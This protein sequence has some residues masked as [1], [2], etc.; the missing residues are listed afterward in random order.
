MFAKLTHR[1]TKDL[2][3]VYANLAAGKVIGQSIA[4]TSKPFYTNCP[5]YVNFGPTM[6]C[7]L[8]TA[9]QW[10]GADIPRFFW[11]LLGTNPDDPRS[12]LA[13]GFHDHGCEDPRIPQVIADAVF[14]TLLGPIRFNGE[15]L[16][17]LGWLRSKLM[18]VAVRAYS[19]FGRPVA[20][21]FRKR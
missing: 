8:T 13:S 6:S 16:P 9:Y 2:P 7:E 20:R 18:Y 17:G 12:L 19:I 3:A 4:N 10:N 14:V 1:E 11:S 15:R 21:L 5:I